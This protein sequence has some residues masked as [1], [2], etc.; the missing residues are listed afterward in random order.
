MVTLFAVLYE[1][2]G[3]Y[4]LV[5]LLDMWNVHTFTR[6]QTKQVR[7]LCLDMSAASQAERDYAT[8]HIF[9]EPSKK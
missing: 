9:I 4:E 8:R 5:A 2:E 7:F 6:I 1:Q 3:A